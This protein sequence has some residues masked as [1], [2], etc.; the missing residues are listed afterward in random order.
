MA[1]YQYLDKAGLTKAWALIKAKCLNVQPDWNQTTTTADDYIKNKPTTLPCQY[2]LTI[3]GKTYNGASAVSVSLTDLNVYSKSEV[4]SLVAV[5]ISIEVVSTLPP[6]TSGDP[7]KIYLVPKATPQTA[8]VYDEY[9][10]IPASDDPQRAAYYEKIG[11]TEI[12]LSGYVQASEMS[13]ITYSEI[14]AIIV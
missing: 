5:K 9:V 14:E 4:D 3:G 13:T 1:N 7:T 2:D 11:D 12:D 8:N 6:T 10:F